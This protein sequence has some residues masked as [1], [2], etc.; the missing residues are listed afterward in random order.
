MFFLV[1][2]FFCFGVETLRCYV[3][4]FLVLVWRRIQCV[5]TF[6]VFFL[7]RMVWCFVVAFCPAIRS[8]GGGLFGQPQGIAP[9][10]Y[11]PTWVCSYR[12]HTTAIRAI[13]HGLC[14]CKSFLFINNNLKSLGRL[15]RPIWIRITIG[16]WSIGLF[17]CVGGIV[18]RR[19]A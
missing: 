13:F 7:E 4:T 17:F 16:A 5:F 10:M 8:Y 1:F 15:Q 3:F 19:L 6:F 12:H 2:I 9:T 14:P 18:L 11:Q